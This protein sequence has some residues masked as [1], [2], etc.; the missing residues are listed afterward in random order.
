[1]IAMLV[2]NK[3]INTLNMVVVC[4]LLLY[5]AIS[6]GMPLNGCYE[7]LELLTLLLFKPMKNSHVCI[8]NVIAGWDLVPSL[9]PQSHPR[10]PSTPAKATLLKQIQEDLPPG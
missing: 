7:S 6:C 1:M 4:L 2:S 5:D 10:P 8:Q 3:N 9:N